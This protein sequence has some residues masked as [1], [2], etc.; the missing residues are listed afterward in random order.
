M[1]NFCHIIPSLS[2]LLRAFCF[3]QFILFTSSSH[4]LYR[5]SLFNQV[6][7]LQHKTIKSSTL[8]CTST[9]TLPRVFTPVRHHR[10]ALWQSSHLS[11]T[12]HL[13][14]RTSNPSAISSYLLNHKQSWQH[15]HRSLKTRSHHYTLPIHIHRHYSYRSLI[16]RNWPLHNQH[17]MDQIDSDSYS[18]MANTIVKE[19]SHHKWIIS[20]YS[21]THRNTH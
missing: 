18:A 17:R 15:H 4:S 12:C 1:V 14:L 16:S 13:T 21:Q 6:L 3:A 20:Y 10:S 9:S 8:H 2:P 5:Y 7:P 19:W 11:W